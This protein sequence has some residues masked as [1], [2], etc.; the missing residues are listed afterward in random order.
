MVKSVATLATAGTRFE[1]DIWNSAFG[2]PF[3]AFRPIA[4][5]HPRLYA[6]RDMK[7]SISTLACPSWTLNQILDGVS[8]AGIHGV[9]F[10]GLGA[11]I[12]ITRHVAFT[13][14]LESTLELFHQ[15]GLE[16]PCLNTSI[17]LVTPATDRWQM[18]LEE[19]QR[20]A[21]LAEHCGTQSL[22][23]FGG[24]VPKSMTR[25]EGRGLA[26]RHL[27]QIVKICQTHHCRPILET[28]DDWATSPRVLELI[29]DLTPE[30]VGVLWDIEHPYRRGESPID[31]ARQLSR[32]IRN[33]HVKDSLMVEGKAMPK[34]LGEG[35]LPL[36]DAV[37]ALREIGYDG[38]LTLETEKRWHPQTA[39]EPEISVPQFAQ[40]MRS[41]G[42]V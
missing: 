7:L 3:R 16:M 30:E 23:I 15:R 21:L 6:E 20:Y 9:D 33:V 27:R 26:Q 34:L 25:D 29:H 19:C 12:D 24:G 40:Y 28:H 18:M 14:E 35:D 37:A 5:T 13:A 42:A 38:W 32:F 17:T 1:F 11:E 2:I 22:R 41:I 39:P 36:R 10:R 31:T 4:H 8:A